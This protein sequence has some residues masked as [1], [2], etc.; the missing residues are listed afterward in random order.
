LKEASAA[1]QTRLARNRSIGQDALKAEKRGYGAVLR[2]HP[3]AERPGALTDPGR[4]RDFERARQGVRVRR[5]PSRAAGA[6]PACR[7]RSAQK[8]WSPA[9]GTTTDGAPARAAE[10][11]VPEPP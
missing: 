7:K 9:K 8:N 5:R 6:I 11:E 3:L 2:A 1:S 4:G 10:R